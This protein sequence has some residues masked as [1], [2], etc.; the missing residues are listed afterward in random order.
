MRGLKKLNDIRVV[1]DQIQKLGLEQ[2]ILDKLDK[3]GE[4]AIDAEI[5][6]VDAKDLSR[7]QDHR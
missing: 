5:E 3:Q 1:K 6:E 7:P 2:E 4:A